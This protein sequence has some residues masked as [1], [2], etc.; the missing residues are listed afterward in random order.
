MKFISTAALLA[1]S[2]CFSSGALRDDGADAEAAAAAVARGLSLPSINRGRG[3]LRAAAAAAADGGDDGRAARDLQQQGGAGSTAA[4][5]PL[6][7]PDTLYGEG[8]LVSAASVTTDSTATTHNFVCKSEF[9]CGNAGYAPGSLYGGEAWTTDGE[10][11][12]SSLEY[13]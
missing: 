6:Y 12:V 1:A 11:A 3:R 5:Y 13:A 9:W 2:V 4:C 7:K 8:S 10:C